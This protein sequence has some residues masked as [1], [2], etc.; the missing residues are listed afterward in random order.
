[1]VSYNIDVINHINNNIFCELKPSKIHGVGV[2]SI[3]DIDIG[4][5]L[6]KTWE[7]DSGI[8]KVPLFLID[9]HIQPLLWRHFGPSNKDRKS[10]ITVIE[11]EQSLNV[12]LF[13][14]INFEYHTISFVNHSDS[15]NV[16]SNLTS[17]R[18]IEKG[19]EIVRCYYKKILFSTDKSIL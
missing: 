3:R 17:L 7:G 11:S 2:F 15:P 18:K 13:K 5:E 4:T 12:S 8:Y 16:D 10:M 6:V 1:M 19:E 9:S 14:G